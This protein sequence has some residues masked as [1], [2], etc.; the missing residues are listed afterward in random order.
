MKSIFLSFVLSIIGLSLFAQKSKTYNLS[1]KDLAKQ[2]DEAIPLGNG[3]I[4]A[5]IW[6][7][8][9]TIRLSLDRADLWDERKAFPIEEHTF[10]WV[11]EQVKNKTYAAAQK[12]GDSPYDTYP[13]PTKLPAAA[14]T[15]NLPSL[16]KV[17]SN[18]LDIHT[19][20][21]TLT[22]DNGTIFTNFV[23]ATQP[24]GYF[25]IEGPTATLAT[26][27]LVPHTYQA[28]NDD[29]KAVSVVSGQSLTRLGYKGGQIERSANQ[30][31]IH[32][33]TY[34]GR[35]FE[36]L[37]EWRMISPTKIIGLWTIANNNKADLSQEIKQ[38]SAPTL[39]RTHENW[40]ANYWSK[41]GIQ[42]P[43]EL[44]ERQYYL[45][46][47]KL[48]S[49]ARNG[50]PAITLQAVWTADNGG[51]P[52]WK[53]D[54]HNDL[55]TQLSY[56]PAYTANRLEEAKTYTDWLW[57]VRPANLEYTQQYF[58]VSGLNIPGVLTLN[59]YPMGGWIQ[60]SLSPT[61]SAW[62]A[63]HFYWQWKYSMDSEFLKKQAYPYII[64]S[65]TFLKNITFLK[66][67]KRYLPLSSSPEY[68]DNSI[69]AWFPD[70]TNFDLGLAHFLFSA[71]AE[72]NEAV[73]Q[74]EEA[75]KWLITKAELPPYALNQ[76]GMLV[77]VD[78]PMEHSHRHMSPYMAI[79]P[80]AQLDINKIEDKTIIEQ[81]LTHL[82][83]LGTRAWVGYSFSWIACL[84]ARAKQSQQAVA[85]LQKF[86]SNFCSVNSF[87]LNGDQ[88][89]GE[90]SGFTYR[91]FTLEG[92]FAF[93][94]GVHELLIQS[95]PGY[96]EIFPAIPSQWENVAFENLRT[97]GGFLVSA[98]RIKGQ[99]TH[100]EVLAT[101]P[102]TFTLM[103]PGKLQ[104]KQ[105]K[106]IS[107]HKNGLLYIQLKKGEKIVLEEE[108]KV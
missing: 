63:Q 71:A 84:H 52:P 70:W 86:A 44:L 23:H 28:A 105:G 79:Y 12:W 39:R 16:G 83:K 60:Y 46:L 24:I 35:Y 40:W 98:A 2:W 67:G 36:V 78:K 48:G 21:H 13:Y 56:W 95:K 93:A 32:Q 68:N 20:T 61:V 15:F 72:I 19:A 87:H 27:T 3:M 53:G 90:Y 17:I 107:L 38:I 59:G 37:L 62:T 50:A 1:F 64:E 76:T 85:N 92:N 25:E 41:S 82:E 9:N 7:K 106:K 104:A 88:K 77:A 75:K 97:E 81:S 54:F 108:L 30:Q 4:G 51:L 99:R 101:A 100:I 18:T 80:L 31:R 33:T 96:V 91:P 89:G 66:N 103:Y 102:G 6:D 47:Y 74:Q 34:D 55:N 5:L 14:L 73:G 58:G 57:K 22:F 42:I 10:E 43:D 94:Q 8:E 69:N 45:E 29:G 11:T 49:S 65:A 26:P